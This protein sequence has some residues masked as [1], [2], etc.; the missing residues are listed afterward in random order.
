MKHFESQYPINSREKEIGQILT[1]IKSGNF[2]QTISLPGGGR[3]QVLGFL[4]YNKALRTKHLGEKEKLFHFVLCNFSEIRNRP[5]SD[6]LKFLFL[7]T[8]ESLTT[9]GL[10]KIPRLATLARNDNLQF[11]IFN[12]LKKLIEHLTLERNINIV[13]LFDNFDEYL[14]MVTQDFFKYLKDLR[15]S[16]P[17]KFSTV[18]AVNRPLE[19]M[20]DQQVITDIYQFIADHSVYLNLYDLPSL[21]FRISSIEKAFAKTIKKEHLEKIIALTGGHVN[22][23]RLCVETILESG[24]DGASAEFLLRHKSIQRALLDIWKSFTPAEQ[25]ILAFSKSASSVQLENESISYLTNIGLLKDGKLTIKLLE[26]FLKQNP[27]IQT[28]DQYIVFDAV[29]KEIKKGNFPISDKLTFFEYNLLKFFLQNPNRIVERDE[30]INAVWKNEKLT[31]GV[32][33]EALDQLV[34]RARRKIENN[35]NAPVHLQT[36]KGRG[37]RFNP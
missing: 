16:A 22:L 32:T 12:N 34:F 19:T 13:F 15:R 5:L 6:V 4:A 1:C 27:S 17:Y 33:D 20:L 7:S 26:D 28:T 23:T 24:V 2:N 14:A 31:A 11:E 37:F 3:S 30:I 36:I 18:F 25:N 8:V 29:T 35:P 9:I 21:E 10:K